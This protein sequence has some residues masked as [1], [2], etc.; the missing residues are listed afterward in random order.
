MPPIDLTEAAEVVGNPP[1][2][3]VRPIAESRG[4]EVA[5]RDQA[6]APRATDHCPSAAGT[7]TLHHWLLLIGSALVIAV[8]FALEVRDGETIGIPELD[9]PLPGVCTF[10]RL[11]G[12]PCPGCGLT[13]CFVSIAHGDVIAALTFNAAGLLI[14]VVVAAQIPYRAVQLWRIRRGLGELQMTKFAIW[15]LG[16]IVALM[17]VQW[18]FRLLG[19]IFSP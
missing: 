9:R 3:P 14:F 10:R 2:P 11:T 15:L 13:R 17:L 12:Q 6:E 8:S 1:P 18:A 16:G 7:G 5:M 4:C 19:G